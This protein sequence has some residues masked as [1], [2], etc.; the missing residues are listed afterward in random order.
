MTSPTPD[1]STRPAGSRSGPA[2]PRSGSSGLAPAR[3]AP[4]RSTPSVVD[5]DLAQRVGVRLAPRGPSV[6]LSLAQDAVAELSAHATAATGHVAS[7]TGLEVPGGAPV[8]V[9][10]RATWVRENVDAFR[11][12][13]DP[14]LREAVAT[15][16]ERASAKAQA[17]TGPLGTLGRLGGTGG[18]DAALAAGSKV[19]GTEMGALLGWM[20]SRVLGQYDVFGPRGGQLLLVAPN[21]VHVE[22]E[23]RV[24]PRDFRLWVAL[25]E[26]TH[27]VQFAVAPWLADHLSERARG[28]SS[29]VLGGEGEDSPTQ[30]LLALVRRLAAPGGLQE[31]TGGSSSQGARDPDDP[32]SAGLASAL[33]GPAQ[34]RAMAEVTAVMSLLEG[35]ADVV[36]DEVGPSVI[37]SVAHIRSRFTSRRASGRSGLDRLVRGLLGMDAK[38]RQYTDGARFVR[39]VVGQVGH[40]GLNEVWSGPENLPR[41]SE[42]VESARWVARVHG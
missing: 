29:D 13:L 12:L 22:R 17:R 2:E 6:P 40:E 18:S 24:D 30:R 20:S 38:L 37:P 35:H 21:V 4:A 3:S 11:S 9:V 41:P 23:M 7:V 26:E 42:I 39:E 27:R 16:I 33:A 19:T 1:G 8:R 10:D 15:R 14:V 32:L 28:L 36:M 5:W 25:H 31:L 34:R